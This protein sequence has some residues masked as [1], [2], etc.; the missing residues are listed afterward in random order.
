ME[1]LELFDLANPDECYERKLSVVPQQSL[2]LLNSSLSLTHARK[3]ARELN[4]EEGIL[5]NDEAFVTAAFERILTRPPTSAERERCLTFLKDH[6]Q[7]FAGEVEQ[8][9]FP[10][11]SVAQLAPSTDPRLRARENLVHV[12]FSH[13]DFVTIR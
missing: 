3:I 2:A 10:A 5:D 11:T 9:K 1:F 12:L 7:Q 6:P 4:S 13:N 8:R